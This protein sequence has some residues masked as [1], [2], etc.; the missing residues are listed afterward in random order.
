M[1]LAIDNLVIVT[2]PIR[3]VHAVG[4]NPEYVVPMMSAESN[5]RLAPDPPDP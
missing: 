5:P 3:Q 4:S 2:A 1:E